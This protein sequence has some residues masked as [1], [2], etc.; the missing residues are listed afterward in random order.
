[1]EANEEQRRTETELMLLDL[2]EK[3][4]W[5]EEE[6]DIWEM[7]MREERLNAEEY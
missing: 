7:I 4:R 1:V 6:E 3:V 5:R 2:T